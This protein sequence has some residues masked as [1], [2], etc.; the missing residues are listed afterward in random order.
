MSESDTHPLESILRQCAVHAP[1]PWYPQEDAQS[2]GIPRD[3]LE[4]LLDEL[5]LAGLVRLTDWVQSKGQGYTLTPAGAAAMSS[6]HLLARLRKGDVP[7]ARAASAE[8]VPEGAS[9]IFRR[10]ETVRQA[11]LYP[12][13]PNVTLTLIF[14]NLGFFVIGCFLSW[15][16]LGSAEPFIMA[17]N[18][19]RVSEILHDTGLLRP[20]DIFPMH[21]WWR[22]LSCCFV[23]IG[24][25]HLLVNMVSLWMVGPLLERV[26]GRWN[27]LAIYLVSGL[28]GSLAMVT[29]GTNGGAGASGAL[30]GIVASLASW[31]YLN[32]KAL[33]SGAAQHLGAS[34]APRVRHQRLHHVSGALY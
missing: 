12:T 16:R 27:Y 6:P 23:H 8:V 4:P 1:Q 26:W 7:V 28:C 2:L 31:V 19:G 18:D 10:G 22:L 3:R 17:G 5:R 30:W 29:F 25:L 33:P 34:V 24:G 11:F 20:T 21:Q 32:R 13:R 14:L 15:L 9:T